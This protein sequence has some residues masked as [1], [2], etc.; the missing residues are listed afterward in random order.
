MK[1]LCNT[2]SQ[3][4]FDFLCSIAGTDTWVKVQLFPS[5]RT[6]SY[7]QIVDIDLDEGVVDV[8]EVSAEHIDA[9]FADTPKYGPNISEIFEDVE[10]WDLEGIS[11]VK[12]VETLSSEDIRLALKFNNYND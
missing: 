11:V 2:K 4:D 12:P 5:A 9:H 1:I 3:S 8:H 7:I 6:L 10:I